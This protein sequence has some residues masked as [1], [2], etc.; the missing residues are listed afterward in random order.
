MPIQLII[1]DLDG[2]LID[3]IGDI[4]CA[5]NHAFE[6]YTESTLTSEETVGMIGEGASKLIKRAALKHGLN[7]N[8]EVVLERFAAF[9]L[10]HP[11]DKTTI[12]PEV[13][14]TLEA[15][16]AYKKAV[17]SNK[18]ESLSLNILARLGLATYFDMVIGSDTMPEQKPSPMTIFHVLSGLN[19]KPE[20]AI[21]V[22]D[23]SVDMATGK[24]A[25]VRTIAVTYGYGNKGFQHKADFIINRFSQLVQLIKEIE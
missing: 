3:S 10:A 1:F 14:Q 15:L 19:M 17:V 21:I 22:G 9:Y 13:R 23:S 5:L 4:T 18:F 24:A 16:A 7:L 20:E 6:P 25:R 12:Y 8:Q 11:D 2:T